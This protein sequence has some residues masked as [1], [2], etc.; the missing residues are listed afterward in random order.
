MR[1]LFASPGPVTGNGNECDAVTADRCQ[2]TTCGPACLRRA[3][4][5]RSREVSGVP[6]AAGVTS[7]KVRLNASPMRH[8][9]G[10]HDNQAFLS[11]G[12]TMRRVSQLKFCGMNAI[13]GSC[14]SHPLASRP[15]LIM[16]AVV[17]SILT[18]DRSSFL[19]AIPAAAAGAS[20]AT[21]DTLI[22]EELKNLQAEGLGLR[23]SGQ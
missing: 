13:E 12:S 17:C 10:S 3:S 22:L 11:Q 16:S 14:F 8:G 23:R 5:T 18:A 9:D 15:L 7:T 6:N 4:A 19:C 2:Q 21:M 20:N 1:I